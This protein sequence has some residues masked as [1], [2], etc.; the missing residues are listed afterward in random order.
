MPDIRLLS[1]VND[2]AVSPRRW[3]VASDG[4]VNVYA[5]YESLGG[6][7]LNI[8]ECPDE[9]VKPNL[10]VY[11]STTG[12]PMHLNV[13]AGSYLLGELV[14]ATNPQGVTFGVRTLSKENG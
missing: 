8:Y 12:E 4:G 6:G 13:S 9:T 2:N 5:A 3:M 14:G 11:S 1:N 7:T 10:P